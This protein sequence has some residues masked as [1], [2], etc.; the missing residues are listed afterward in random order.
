MYKG[1]SLPDEY[2]G[3]STRELL[4]MWDAIST[5]EGIP[6]PPPEAKVIAMSE[7]LSEYELSP[8][9]KVGA[10]MRRRQGLP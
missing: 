8:E 1:V 9:A 10:E 2:M 7:L 6:G 4:E 5:D 3:Y